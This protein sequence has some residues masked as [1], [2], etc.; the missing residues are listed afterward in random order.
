MLGGSEATFFFGA[1]CV[2][3]EEVVDYLVLEE[4]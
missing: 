2:Q 3:H 1:F 4:I